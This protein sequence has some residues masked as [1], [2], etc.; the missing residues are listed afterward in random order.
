LGNPLK[1]VQGGIILGDAD[2]VA[3]VKRFMR[4]PSLRE[5][6]AYRELQNSS[7]EP[8]QLLRIITH[9]CGFD[10]GLLSVRHRHGAVRGMVAELLYRYCD[11]TQ[12]QI[13]RLLGDLDYISVHMLRK[14]LQTRLVTDQKLR[15]RFK[16]LEEKIKAEMYNVKI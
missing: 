10:E 1:Q 13:G 9:G 16:E 2:F 3:R 5:Q 7:L 8:A 12:A 6:P 15:A 14:R 11:I 4:R